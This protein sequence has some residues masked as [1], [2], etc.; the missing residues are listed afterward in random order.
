MWLS[1]NLFVYLSPYGK[2]YAMYLEIISKSSRIG[3]LPGKTEHPPSRRQQAEQEP[4]V[5][6]NDALPWGR[7]EEGGR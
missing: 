5:P 6:G 7:A 3:P 1:L 2:T 4:G